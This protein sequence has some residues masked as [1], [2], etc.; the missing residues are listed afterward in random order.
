MMLD[1]TFLVDLVRGDPGAR[2]FLEEA[3]RG[4]EAIRI[5]APA[6]ARFWEALERSRAPPRDTDRIRDVL[7]N[8]GQAELGA[9]AAMRAGKLLGE[10]ARENRPMDVYD[11][12]TA[13][14]SLEADEPLVTRAS[15]EFEHVRDLKLRAY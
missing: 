7:S 2:T 4:S 15:R 12:L 13:A 11:A 8:V 10:A 9:A 1:T 6:L 14:V 3:E 5:P